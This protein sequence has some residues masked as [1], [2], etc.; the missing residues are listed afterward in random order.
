VQDPLAKRIIA[1]NFKPGAHIAA[2]VAG[3]KESL[4]FSPVVYETSKTGDDRAA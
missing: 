3:D 4:A 2:S 1:G